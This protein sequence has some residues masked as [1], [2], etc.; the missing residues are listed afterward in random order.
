MLRMA[1]G[2]LVRALGVLGKRLS[3]YLAD[4]LRFISKQLARAP[5]A[6]RDK[7]RAALS[8]VTGK[9]GTID[10]HFS[11]V[12]AESKKDKPNL[13]LIAMVILTAVSVLGDEV[14]DYFVDT[15]PKELEEWWSGHSSTVASAKPEIS[16][17]QSYVYVLDEDGN[18]E[19]TPEE[20]QLIRDDMFVVTQVAGSV[21]QAKLFLRAV[22][23]LTARAD[24]LENILKL[25]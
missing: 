5:K 9:R 6:T 4:L 13:E 1:A 8:D 25:Q 21:G 11:L 20:L 3:P 7:L 22:R 12:L 17:G 24:V 14:Y 2:A 10:E 19:F 18:G 16:P 15:L 23:R